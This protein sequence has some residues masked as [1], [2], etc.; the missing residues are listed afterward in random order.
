MGDKILKTHLSKRLIPALALVTC[1]IAVLLIYPLNAISSCSV[2]ANEIEAENCK[3]GNPSSEWDINGAG[4]QSIQ[5]FATDIS[6]NKG[7]TV[8]FKIDTKATSYRL[9]IYRIGYYGNMGARKVATVLPSATLPQ[10]QSAC[11]NDTATKLTDCGNWAESASWTVPANAVSGVYIAKL[12]RSDTGGASHIIFIVR[13]DT[14]KSDILFK[15][16]DTTWQ[17]YNTYGLGYIEYPDYGYPSQKA[18]KASYNRPFLTR[19]VNSGMGAFN[20]FFQAEYP[21]VRWLESNGYNVS[22]FTSVDADRRGAQILDHKAFLSVGHDEYWSGQERAN[23]EAARTAGVNL[24][25]FGGNEVYRKVRWENSID[26]SGTPYRTM[27]CYNESNA[28]V[29]TDPLDPPIWTG[30]WRNPTFS[31]PADGGRPENALSGTLFTVSDGPNELGI[32]MNV[33][34]ANGRLRFWRNT[35]VASLVAGQVATLGDRVVGYE[36][37]EDIDNGYRPAGLVQLSSTTTPTIAKLLGDNIK[38]AADIYLPGT[39]THVMT[40]YRAPSRALVFSAGT[41]HFSWGLDSEHDNGPSIID[42]NMRQATVNLFADMGVQPVALQTGLTIATASTDNSAPVS[43]IT[44]PTSG[45]TVTTGVTI[46]GTAT[47][48]GGGV[49]GA[50]E[51]STDNGSTWHPASGRESWSYTWTPTTAGSV[52]IRSRAVDDSGNI[53]TPAPGV[54]VTVASQQSNPTIWSGTTIPGLVD[55]G[56]DSAVELGV[57]FRSDVNGYVTGIRFYKASTN[58]GTHTGSLWSSTGTLI[59]TATFTGESASGWQQVNFTTPVA[60]TANTVYVASY[61]ATSGHYSADVNYF[62]GKGMDNP[63]LHALASGVSGTNGVYA[64]GSTS[65]FPSQSW[66]NANYWVDVAVSATPPATLTSIALTPASPTI[67]SGAT[68]QFTAT[69]TYSDSSTQNVTSLATWTSSSTGIATITTAGIATGVSA[70]SSTITATLSGIPRST[71]LSVLAGPLTITTATLPNAALNS[72]YSAVLTASGGTLPYTW[73]LASGTLPA[74]LTINSTTGS[75][76]G[77]PTASGTFNFNI[78]VAD[79]G[80]TQ[81]TATKAFS[82]VVTAQANYTIWPGTTVPGLVDG[83]PDSAVELGVKFRSDVN[84]YLTGIRFYKASTNAGTHTGSLW[85]STGT[86]ITTATF[87]GESASGWQQVNFTTPVAITANTVYVA[88]YHAN[89]GHYSA[90]LNYFTGKGMDS[91]PLHALASGVSGSNGVYAYGATS[92]FPNQ[93]W[94]NANYWVDVSVS[95]TPPATLTSIVVT[96]TSQ[97]IMSGA[98]QQFTATGTYSDASTQNVTSQATWTSSSTSV[99][100]ITSAALATA[101][102]AGSSTITATLS[103]VAGTTTLAVQAPLAITTTS[104][105]NGVVNTSYSNTLTASGG[106][107][108]YTWAVAGGALPTGLTLNSATGAISGMPT[109]TGSFS[110]TVQATDSGTPKQT[111]TKVLSI[112]ITVPPPT[113]T[114]IALT[115]SSP[116]I[117]SS[118]TQQFTATG[119]YSDASTQN[120]TSQVTWTSSITSVATI[121]STGMAT[122]VSVGSS[123]ITAVLSG[124]TGST[125]LTVQAAPL[126]I[127]TATLP[128]ATLNSAY[129]APLAASGGTVPYTWTIASGALPAGLTLN[130]TTGSITGTPTASGTF[131]F[132]VQAADSTNPK[133]NA[134]KALSISVAAQNKPILVISSVSNPFSRYYPEILRAEGFN[135]FVESDIATVSPTGLATYDVVILGEIPL[136]SSHVT[137]FSNWVDAGGNLIAMRPDKKLANLLGLTDQSSTLSDA[138]LLADTSQEPGAG[139]VNQTIQFHSSADRYLLNGA[140]GLATLYSD[141]STTASA[142]AVTLRSVGVNGGQA[143]AFTYDLARSVVYTRQGNPAWSGQDRDGIAPIRSDDLF[144]GDASFDPQANWIDMSKVAIPQADEQQRLLGN[145][146]IQMNLDK[147]PLPRFWYLPRSLAA[148]VVMTGD[149][150]GNNGTSGRFDDFMAISPAGCSVDNWECIRGTS[151]IYPSTPITPA[152]AANYTIA[153]FEI[154]AHVTTN[155]LDWT[156]YTLETFFAGDLGAWDA[157]Y[158]TLPQPTTSRL[159]CIVWSD[160]STMPAVELNHGIRF[161]A[162]YYYWPPGWVNDHPGM[163]TGSGMPMRFTDASGNLIDVYQATTQ[164]TDESGQSYPYTIDTLL[165]KAIGTEGYYGVFTANMHTDTAQS[166]EA[167]AIVNSALTRGIPVVSARQM[168]TWMDGRNGSSFSSITWNGTTLSFSVNAAQGAN[169]LVAMVPVPAGKIVTSIS[170]GGSQIPFTLA[171][172]KG[173]QY[174]RFTA[175]SGSYL[176]D[177]SLDVTPPMVVSVSPANGL[178]GVDI[179][180][181]VSAIFSEALDPATLSD[182]TFELRDSGNNL[183]PGTVTFNGVTITAVLSPTASLADSMSFTATVKGGATG[184]KDIAGNPLANNV[185]WSFTTVAP[186]SATVTIW[187]GTTVP[188]LVDGGPDGAVELGVK[189]RSDVAGYITGIRFYKANTNT[190]T[191]TGSLWSSTGT[192]LAT[193][194]FSS[195]SASGWQQ[196]NFAT[197]VAIT[198]N[199]IYVASYHANNGHYSADTNYFTGKGMDSAPLHALA[200]GVS[201]ANGVYAYGTISNFPNQSWNNANYWVD[202]VFKP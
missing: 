199:T 156:P 151:Y 115:P 164:M 121:T 37:D 28:P 124:I 179:G 198:A 6:V 131:N 54:T 106:T 48:S 166:A 141:A 18:T 62:T 16:S 169:G 21:M 112:T 96:P 32:S 180:T 178:A 123:T 126:T 113:L 134:T 24:A 143:A 74:G 102:N 93:T 97:T 148:A 200:S 193:A 46:T 174:A 67:T 129:S 92:I 50:I 14:G 41:V 196:V 79:S 71:S 201:G 72:T 34:Q 66:N 31:P 42:T 149:D 170:K 88:S 176:V 116:T 57:K 99:A 142:P 36:F 158:S 175:M 47:D 191:H 22:Y 33:P 168:L 13:D 90:D 8:H 136:T 147:K 152:Q 56:P 165:D 160:Y 177:Y 17:S 81:Q 51:I 135:A 77:I 197:P 53:E 58:T 130:S 161:D 159:H 69:G 49:V 39:A 202:V 139:I 52:T 110:F 186:S 140:S 40:L 118:A 98:T 109:A 171:T 29:P 35:T 82:V 45:T 117:T 27:V 75:I 172:I 153:G 5:G 108:P 183:I 111:V 70:G 60:I 187:S 185:I 173:F 44:S 162:N 167:D 133:Q 15:T 163:F 7:E 182:S 55:G 94:N 63:P 101:V 9:D 145:L 192:K 181:K 4:D 43:V 104:L 84:G 59:S 146:I 11:I 125:T 1:I 95:A 10:S 105:S 119:T 68:Q 114:S 20:W 100:T 138:Y 120:I 78:K 91:V 137:M 184:V 132:T 2:P 26:G 150:H 25:F 73:T 83:G 87:T 3:A 30:T 127:T 194:T 64:Y 188:G 61:H 85:S 154:G 23:V 195:E 144:Y 189:F 155:C 89:S 122:G 80:A 12:V 65:T 19:A 107:L 86:L 76:T 103:G 128:G 38:I 157:K 190:G